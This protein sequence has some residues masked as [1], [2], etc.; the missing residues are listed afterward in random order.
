M[1]LHHSLQ[2][3]AV[4]WNYNSNLFI[5]SFFYVP[6][7]LSV[8]SKYRIEARTREVRYD[9]LLIIIFPRNKTWKSLCL[10]EILLKLWQLKKDI[11]VKNYKIFWLNCCYQMF[12]LIS[13]PESPH[14]SSYLQACLGLA[15]QW[16]E[17]QDHLQFLG[18]KLCPLP[19]R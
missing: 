5:G 18:R 8:L 6:P 19:P 2:N 4:Y 11:K 7:Y 12:L 9:N 15:D 14:H 16:T 3:I 1:L 13:V 17:H 10:L